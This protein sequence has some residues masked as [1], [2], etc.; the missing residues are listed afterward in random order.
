MGQDG[1]KRAPRGP[2]RVPSKLQEGAIKAP[3]GLQ[4]GSKS[5]IKPSCNSM[6]FQDGVC[7]G[8]IMF[9]D[10]CWNDIR[11]HTDPA[12]AERGKKQRY[13]FVIFECP[14]HRVHIE[15]K[16][17]RQRSY[18]AVELEVLKRSRKRRHERS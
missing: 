1:P 3:R 8:N 6:Q 15:H 14:Y 10:K 12:L 17:L 9:Y 2:K 16:S 5:Y 13:V 4:Q 7:E 18:S 11:M